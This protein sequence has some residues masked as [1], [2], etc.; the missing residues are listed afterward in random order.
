MLRMFVVAS[1]QVEGIHYWPAAATDPLL[2]EAHYLQHPH[3]HVFHI[4]VYVRVNHSD[5]QVEVIQLARKIK[6]MAESLLTGT[7]TLSCE[8]LAYAIGCSLE[9]HNLAVAMVR[10]LEDGENG[11]IILWDTD[12]SLIARDANTANLKLW[13]PGDAEG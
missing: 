7:T 8:Q 1:T 3:R 11:A 13:D 12:D 6:T 4:A 9:K 5:R 10:V 2:P